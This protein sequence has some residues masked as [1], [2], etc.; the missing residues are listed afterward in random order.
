MVL[1]KIIKYISKEGIVGAM[2]QEKKQQKI[3]SKLFQ[4]V[5]LSNMGYKNI[6]TT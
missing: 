3:E 4:L 5:V 6:N 1:K 2:S